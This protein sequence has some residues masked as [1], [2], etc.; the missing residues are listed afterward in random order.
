MIVPESPT[1][2]DPYY[3]ELQHFIECLEE[4]RAPDVKAE[5]GLE[6]V[7]IADA[8]LRSMSTRQPVV[9]A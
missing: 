7:R 9:M 6:A 8:A 1:L 3:L 5:D 2:A 4:G